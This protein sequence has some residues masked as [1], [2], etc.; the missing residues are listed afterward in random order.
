VYADV[1]ART[2]AR[3][4]AWSAVMVLMEVRS[5]IM[6]ALEASAPAQ[7]PGALPDDAQA[8]R[9]Q[10]LRLF[11][12]RELLRA[13]EHLAAAR[14][15]HRDLDARYMMKPPAADVA[16]SVDPQDAERLARLLREYTRALSEASGVRALAMLVPAGQSPAAR[17][18]ADALMAAA[19]D[20]IAAMETHNTAANWHELTAASTLNVRSLEVSPHHG[21][22]TPT[23]CRVLCACGTCT[24]S[25]V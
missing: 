6:G 11:Y 12:A 2:A 13:S 9:D 14:A 3:N 25:I 8:L 7:C 24:A 15:R 20:A 16:V 18:A 5:T 21:T 10:Y 23:P 17:S 19:D 22:N 4:Q 1:Q